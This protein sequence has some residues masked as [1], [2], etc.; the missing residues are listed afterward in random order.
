MVVALEALL[1]LDGTDALAA[2]AHSVANQI[3]DALPDD[4]MRRRF[5]E[6]EVVQQISATFHSALPQ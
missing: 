4:T 6:S 5:N 2:E 1:A 3:R